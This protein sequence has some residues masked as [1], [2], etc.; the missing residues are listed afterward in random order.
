M[1]LTCSSTLRAQCPPS[2]TAPW[3]PAPASW[4]GP[5]TTDIPLFPGSPCI[6]EVVYC[7]GTLP[8]GG[9]QIFFESV[10]PFS[11]DCTTGLTPDQLIRD[12][13]FAVETN[14]MAPW[15][16]EIPNCQNGGSILFQTVLA[17]CWYV[18]PSINPNLQTPIY[19]N[20]T[21]D[22]TYCL[23]VCEMCKDAYGAILLTNCSSNM[24]GNPDCITAPPQNPWAPHTCYNISPCN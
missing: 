18:G 12:A 16:P 24:T 8:G 7:W 6:V 21:S 19:Q 5:V 11:G 9:V 15:D 2:G 23:K 17:S 4:V 10:Q 20:C 1:L 14:T 22:E 13:A 3:G